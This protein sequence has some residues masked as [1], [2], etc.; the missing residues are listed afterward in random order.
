MPGVLVKDRLNLA[1]SGNPFSH[2]RKSFKKI[3]PRAFT[4]GSVLDLDK[5]NHVLA[6]LANKSIQDAASLAYPKIIA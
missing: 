3:S 5:K 6:F 4:E 2:P 1:L